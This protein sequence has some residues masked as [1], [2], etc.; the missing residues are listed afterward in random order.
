MH[1]EPPALQTNMSR[2][3][4]TMLTLIAFPLALTV[5]LLFVARW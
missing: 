3:G 4:L 5:L 1:D 2:R